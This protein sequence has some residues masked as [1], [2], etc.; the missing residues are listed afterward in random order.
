MPDVTIA[1]P[2]PLRRTL[3]PVRAAALTA[4]VEHCPY[5]PD[6]NEDDVIRIA[7]E[8]ERYLAGDDD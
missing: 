4:A 8:F 7:K 5:F 6:V 2:F 1:N 3:D